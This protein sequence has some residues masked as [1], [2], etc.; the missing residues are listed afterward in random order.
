MYNIEIENIDTYV[1][2]VTAYHDVDDDLVYHESPRIP[3]NGGGTQ[4]SRIRYNKRIKPKKSSRK[5]KKN[6]RKIR[7][8]SKG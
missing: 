4:H 2:I 3:P 5:G 1:M 7:N 6:K 8:K